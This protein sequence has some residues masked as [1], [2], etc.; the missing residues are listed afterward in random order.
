MFGGGFGQNTTTSSDITVTL[1]GTTVYGDLYG[2]S[3]LGCVNSS[4]TADTTLVNLKSATLHGSIFG[5][6]K[7]QVG[8][9]STDSITA[10]SNGKAIVNIDVYDQ[11]L[12]GIYGGAYINGNVIGDITVNV[13]ANVG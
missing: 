7:G 8:P 4:A 12:T 9:N 2:G 5:G 10:T 1:N 6:G 13:N 3:A 11:Y